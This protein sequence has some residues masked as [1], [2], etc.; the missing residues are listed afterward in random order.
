MF[1]G[2]II[3]IE[4][5]LHALQRAEERGISKNDVLETLEN[6]DIIHP[7]KGNKRISIKTLNSKIIRIV[8]VEENNKKIV[9][10]VTLG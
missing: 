2:G 1:G 3:D 7:G 4:F 6:P 5:S 10:T 9:I 8:Y